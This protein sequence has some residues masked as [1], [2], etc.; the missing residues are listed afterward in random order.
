MA[1]EVT[2]RCDLCSEPLA[3]SATA[4]EVLHMP[5]PA[6]STAS[7]DKLRRIETCRA[8]EPAGIAKFA[9][10]SREARGRLHPGG[11]GRRGVGSAG[12]AL[13]GQG[14]GE[15]LPRAPAARAGVGMNHLPWCTHLDCDDLC[16][17]AMYRREAVAR[18]EV[19]VGE[20]RCPTLAKDRP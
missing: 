5:S 10:E 1:S 20:P 19:A 13:H 15:R 17:V 9:A 4:I 14:L 11:R 18:V 7:D 2:F 8:C 12:D 16:P 3:K 6:V